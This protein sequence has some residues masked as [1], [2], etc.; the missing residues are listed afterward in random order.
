MMARREPGALTWTRETQI[1]QDLKSCQ[2]PQPLCVSVPPRVDL[3]LWF[4]VVTH[5]RHLAT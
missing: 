3:V 4:C 5:P 2:Q 1:N